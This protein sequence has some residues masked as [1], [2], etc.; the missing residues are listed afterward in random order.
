MSEINI[1]AILYPVQGKEERMK[2]LVA[3]MAKD[4][5]EKEDYTLR[6]IMTEQLGVETPDI[7]MIETY[8]SK[9]AADQ[10]TKTSHFKSLFSTMESEH[11]MA[12]PPYI[13]QTISKAGFD[14]DRKMIS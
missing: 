8:K 1:V 10:H 7:V 5:H 4:V 2:E 6:Y 11:L 9:E 13:A 14:L 12:K 3:K